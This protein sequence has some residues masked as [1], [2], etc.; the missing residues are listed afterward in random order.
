MTLVTRLNGQELQRTTTDRM[1]YSI[2]RQI[3]YISTFV[4]L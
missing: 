3:A 2:P 1:V 4:P